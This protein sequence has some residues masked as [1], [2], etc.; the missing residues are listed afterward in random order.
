MASAHVPSGGGTT[1]RPYR[2]GCSHLGRVPGPGLGPRTGTAELRRSRP[3]RGELLAVSGQ[4]EARP[5]GRQQARSSFRGGR[6]IWRSR[7]ALG[8]RRGIPGGRLWLV[9]LFTTSV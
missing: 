7:T 1:A 4:P 8:N 6:A 2:S 3:V 9:V 5:D